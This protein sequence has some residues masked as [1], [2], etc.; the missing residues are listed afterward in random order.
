MTARIF[1]LPKAWHTPLR[2]AF[3]SRGIP[4]RTAQEYKK[5]WVKVPESSVETNRLST[6]V[7][8]D[9]SEH[10]GHREL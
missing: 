5:L 7:E 3:R 2:E 8:N 4:L 6:P 10:N 1:D 9:S